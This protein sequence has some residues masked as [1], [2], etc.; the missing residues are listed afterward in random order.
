MKIQK[1]MTGYFRLLL[2]PLVPRFFA[3]SVDA[4]NEGEPNE[5]VLLPKAAGFVV[6][7]KEG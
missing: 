6:P 7:N 5:P 1:H 2:P 4:V 3:P